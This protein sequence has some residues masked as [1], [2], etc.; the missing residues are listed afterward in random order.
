FPTGGF[1]DGAL[2]HLVHLVLPAL[3]IALA[4]AALTIRTLRSNLIAVLGA[5]YVDTARSK[6]LT[7]RAVLLH[8]VLP[9]SLIS[10]ISV[11]GVHLSWVIGGTVVIEAVF[12][13]PGVGLLFVDSIFARDYPVIQ[14]LTVTFAVLV[15]AINLLT[16]LAYA[17]ADPRVRID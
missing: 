10:A 1:G 5:D 12:A 14:G 15:V 13:L 7:D 4:T 16:D 2:D 9:N 17:A 3:V 8:H 6:G 11:L